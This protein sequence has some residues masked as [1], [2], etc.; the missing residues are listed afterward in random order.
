MKTKLYNTSIKH[1]KLVLL[2]VLYFISIANLI[3]QTSNETALSIAYTQQDRD[4]SIRMEVKIEEMGKRFDQIDRHFDQID[5][6]FEM[7]EGKYQWQF[8]LLLGAMF[9]LFGFIL[10]DRRTFLKPFQIKMEEVETSLQNE[11]TK[12]EKLLATFRELAK[13]DTK[14]AQVL[15]QFNLL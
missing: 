7:M 9:L 3:G 2:L 5:K 6:R 4:R 13:E 10:W 15:K 8:G 1:V 14:V 11:K 12:T